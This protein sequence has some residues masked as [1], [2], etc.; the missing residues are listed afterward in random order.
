M[1]DDF[2]PITGQ[3]QCGA[4]RIAVSAPFVGALYCHCRRCQRRSGGTRALT[5][6]SPP[7]TFSVT[8]GEDKLRVWDP[9]DGWKKAFCADCGSHTHTTSPDDPDVVATR[10]GC[11]DDDPGIRPMAHQFVS[12]ASPLEPIP[13][14]GLP[15]F[16]ERLGTTPPL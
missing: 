12:Y 10:M 2:A 6:L 14:D 3:C 13:D 8:A 16:P 9:G 11:L 15:R 4:V 5:A 1:S 7:G